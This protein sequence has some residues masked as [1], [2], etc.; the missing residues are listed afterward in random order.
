MA[1]TYRVSRNIEASVI[2][3]LKTN[4]DADWTGVTLLKTFS[5]AYDTELP[6]VC[7]RCGTTEHEKAE[8]G[9][10]ATIRTPLILIDIFAKSDGQ[11]LDMKDYV[12]EKIKHGLVYYDYIIESG[13]VKMKTANG[14]LRV[15]GLDDT[16]VDFDIEK[17]KLSPQDRYRHLISLTISRGKVEA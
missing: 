5:R 10:N 16:P 8:I 12:V 6:V 9:G 1:N 3:F 17:D 14:R 15:I 4:F 2:D 13:V 11:R 7:V